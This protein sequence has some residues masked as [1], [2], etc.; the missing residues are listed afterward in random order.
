[1]SPLFGRQTKAFIDPSRGDAEAARLRAAVASGDW[2]AVDQALGAATEP[3]RREFLV[4]AISQDSGDPA[5]ADPWIREQPASAAARLMWGACAAQYAWKVRTGAVPQHVSRDRMAGFHEWLMN[6][7]EQLGHASTLAPDDSAP[8]VNL[9]WCA[10]GLGTPFPETQERWDG[11]FRR[12]PGSELGAMAFTTYIGP[13][14]SGTSE[15]MWEF[16][17]GHVASL[18]EGSPLWFLVPHAHLE[19]WV[20]ERMEPATK[21]HAGRY[22]QEPNV[23]AEISDAYRRYLASPARRPSYLEPQHRE[24]F[25]G[26]FYMMGMR[27]IL[28]KELEL[29]GPG[30]QSLPWG[31]MGSSLDVYQRARE[32]AGLK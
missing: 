14:W 12:N 2:R 26:C 29:V 23:Q 25:A 16:V 21:E 6:A 8:W 19:Q 18:P 1:L 22:F 15:L 10:V 13:R 20:A 28:R 3:L 24:L 27:D 11:V 30:I 4:D 17:R 32:S 31:F 7:E 5:W 9:L